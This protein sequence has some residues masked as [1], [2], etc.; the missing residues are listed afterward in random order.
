MV[1]SGTVQFT[2]QPSRSESCFP[3]GP[4]QPRFPPVGSRPTRSTGL[5]G[6]GLGR[7]EAGQLGTGRPVGTSA[8][9]YPSASC[10]GRFPQRRRTSPALQGDGPISHDIGGKEFWR[11]RGFPQTQALRSDQ[12]FKRVGGELGAVEACEGRG[13]ALRL[14]PE[15]SVESTASTATRMS[16]VST[17]AGSARPTPTLRQGTRLAPGLQPERECRPLQPL[18]RHRI[19]VPCPPCPTTSV[20][21]SMSGPWSAKR[22]T[23]A[24]SGTDNSLG[25]TIP[26]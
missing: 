3:T 11:A 12:S 26:Q 18:D 2:M 21:R 24:L 1:S 17:S 4:R 19:V 14:G 20:A 6:S 15:G 5:G 10:S 8:R 7:N 13:A 9:P 23:C 16:G 22:T 25:S